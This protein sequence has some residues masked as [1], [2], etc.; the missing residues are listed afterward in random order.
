MKYQVMPDLTPIEYEALKA[1]IEERGVLV[2]VEMDED[3]NI[4]DGHH[5]VKAWQQ[6]RS[7]GVNL[8]DYPRMV[9]RGLTEEQKRNHARSLN[10][11]RRH[12]SREQRDE[13]MR[14]MRADGATYQDI[15]KAVGVSVDTAHRA[16]R[17]VVISEIGNE[18]GQSRPASYERR[19]E[20]PAAIP[21]PLK[22]APPVED[23]E[24]ERE[25]RWVGGEPKP[26]PPG[27]N[28]PNGHPTT[29]IPARLAPVE[30]PPVAKPSPMAVHF[31]SETPEHYTP[32]EIIEA[33]I[34]VLGGIDL[35]PCSNSHDNP[36]VPAA[37]HYTKEDDGLAQIWRGVT[38]MNP[39]YGREIN[40]WVDKLVQSYTAGTVPEAIA[41]VP[42][43]VDTQWWKTLTERCS[44]FC[45]VEGRLSF[46]GNDDPAPFPSAIVYFGQNF[47]AFYYTF[48]AIGMVCKIVEPTIDFGD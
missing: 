25:L 18:R 7:E 28:L 31:S 9:R 30:P 20:L 37:T 34:A 24:P 41:L 44:F 21:I 48:N 33:V 47:G 32:A 15:A 35:D 5:R 11:L 4:L 13:V 43:R 10:V 22:M 26:Y 27:T 42:A 39:P 1:D 3:G 45:F 2:P 29:Y 17:E 19:A 8:P 14:A 16:A 36:N 6:L 46:V 40:A 38:Y 12:L 23:A